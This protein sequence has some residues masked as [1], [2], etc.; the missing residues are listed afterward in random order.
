[1]FFL[2]LIMWVI[3]NGR[4]DREVLVTG[5]VLAVPVYLF[6]CLVMRYTPKKEW[7]TVKHFPWLLKY[8]GVLLVE[9]IKANFA[10]IR[11][12]L[13]PKLEPEP[14]LVHF[15]KPMKKD[16]HKVL[17]ANSITLTPGTITVELD[18]DNYAVHALDKE[19]AEG[20]DSSVFVEMIKE[21]E[22]RE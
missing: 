14:I 19:F 13:S 8:I 9:I 6:F 15:K 12:I 2:F 1:M 16:S 4:L 7:K 20:L 11:L 17:L 21:L 18:G 10:V 5:L 3:L 22:E